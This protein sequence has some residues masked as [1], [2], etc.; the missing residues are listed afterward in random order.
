MG[1]ATGDERDAEILALRHQITVL[2]R[3]VT[4][5]Q[6]SET[7]RTILAMLASALDRR[8]LA[9]VFLIMKPDTVIG[10]HR[11]LVARHWTQPAVRKPGRPPVDPEIRRLIIR[12][13]K[14]TPPWGYRR[15]HGE[16][17]RLGHRV[18]ASTVWEI[19]R[20]AGIDPAADRTGPTWTEF[21]RSQA[22]AIIATDFACV[23]RDHASALDPTAPAH[24]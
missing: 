6:F 12:R 19:L 8:R 5:P 15:V 4:R 23:R 7:D 9:D 18:A 24:R 1:F 10:W 20:T 2:Q 3:Q 22:A 14:E 21:I 17:H 13:A 11:R 16:L